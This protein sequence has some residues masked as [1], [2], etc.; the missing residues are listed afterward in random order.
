MA[1]TKSTHVTKKIL[2]VEKVRFRA[3]RQHSAFQTDLQKIVQIAANLPPAPL[4]PASELTKTNWSLSRPAQKKYLEWS[5]AADA[6]FERWGFKPRLA[7]DGSVKLFT[8]SPLSF[9]AS[10]ETAT[11]T[12]VK[13]NTRHHTTGDTMVR[14]KH[15]KSLRKSKKKTRRPRR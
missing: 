5:E 9:E 15:Y 4:I 6:F 11:I 3:L 2:E 8:P 13:L 1:R 14:A 7:D 10:L 12:T